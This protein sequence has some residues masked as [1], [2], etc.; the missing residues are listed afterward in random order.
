MLLY[1]ESYYISLLEIFAVMHCEAFFYARV[2]SENEPQL[3][4]VLESR[5]KIIGIFVEMC[6]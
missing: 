4:D 1:Y 5:C 3:Y 6:I 2:S